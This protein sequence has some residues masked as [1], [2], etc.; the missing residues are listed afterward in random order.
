MA[1][2][3]SINAAMTDTR[4]FYERKRVVVPPEEPDL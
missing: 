1:D 3:Q 4:H 2:E